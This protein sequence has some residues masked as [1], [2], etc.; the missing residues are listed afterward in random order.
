MARLGE[1]PYVVP[2][3]GRED[4]AVAHGEAE[5]Q[6]YSEGLVEQGE[7][8]GAEDGD[9]PFDDADEEGRQKYAD[10]P[11]MKAPLNPTSEITILPLR[12]RRFSGRSFPCF[13]ARK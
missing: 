3:Y 8:V 5:R 9:A 13:S 2:A 10:E 6:G 11:D 4:E 12:V 1:L 7:F